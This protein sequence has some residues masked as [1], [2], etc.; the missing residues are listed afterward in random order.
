MAGPAVNKQTVANNPLGSFPVA[1]VKRLSDNAKI[2]IITSGLSIPDY[3]W[4]ECTYSGNN[5]TGVI[6]YVGGSGGTVIG[7]LNFT[8]SGRNLIS[9]GWV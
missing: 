1:D 4:F 2:Q 9:G 6:F 5:L 3:D 7:E 8:Y